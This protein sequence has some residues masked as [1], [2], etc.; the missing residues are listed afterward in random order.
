M[1]IA[2]VNNHFQLGG[3][4]TVM[5]QLHQ[6]LIDNGHLSTILVAEG[7]DYP[8]R[9]DVIPLYPKLL[10]KLQYTRFNGICSRLAN[11]AK[12]TDRA[13][14]RL[15]RSRYDLIHVHSFHGIYASIKTFADLVSA[16]PLVW[17]FHRFWGVTGG[18]DHPFNCNK[19]FTGCGT[20]P[21][22]GNFA[23]GHTDR[24]AEEWLTK[25][26]LLRIL[27][28]TIVAPSHHLANIVRS[29]PIGNLWNIVT[30]PNGIDSS[31]FRLD[32]KSSPTFKA[33]L[34]LSPDKIILLFT[35]RSFKDPIKG[36]PTIRD[37]LRKL[38]PDG[39]QVVLVG[40]DATWAKEQLPSPWDIVAYEYIDD[41]T[42]MAC[43]YESSDIFMYSSSGENFPCA[44]LEAMS[45]GCCVVS[46]PVDGVLEQVES[47]ISGLISNDLSSQ[48]LAASLHY[49]IENPERVAQL[50]VYARQRVISLFSESRM[51]DQHLSLYS[52]ILS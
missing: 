36:W 11:R 29:S 50:G 30:I 9:P 22:V 13:V 43:I 18:C 25:F 31:K 19:Y 1:N 14:S 38:T 7:R 34:G 26:R 42:H 41:R 40:N 24:T 23:V 17:T 37:A 8:M 51:V 33:R 3:A 39:I 32:R 44:I 20:C 35:N 52:H 2:F 27:P 4:E 28:L 10:S 15:T 21:Q 45:S 5:R 12:W 49:A 47:G 48:S 16:K 6:G 46:S